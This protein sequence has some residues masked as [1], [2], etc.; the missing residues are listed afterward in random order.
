MLKDLSFAVKDGQ[1]LAI[2]GPTGSGKSTI[3][4]LLLRFYDVNS[5]EIKL[6]GRDIKDIDIASVRN[7][8]A[9]V[10]QKPMLFSG[11]VSD[12]IRWGGINLP[13]TMRFAMPPSW[14]RP[15]LSSG[16]PMVSTVRWEV[17]GVNISGG[18]K[19]RISIGARNHKKFSHAHTRRRH[20][21]AGCRDGSQGQGEFEQQRPEADDHYDYATVRKQ[22]CLQTGFLSWITA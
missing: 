21:R 20:Q 13:P 12:N 1:S 7:N 22:Q 10:P 16:C 14:R 15:I 5:G 9:I 11:S 2:I 19:Q 3:A 18:Q 4:W 8:I 17:R 6:S